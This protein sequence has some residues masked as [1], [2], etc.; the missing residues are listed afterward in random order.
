MAIITPNVPANA[1]LGSPLITPGWPLVAVV[2]A[3]PV[4]DKVL[5]EAPTVARELVVAS[6][7]VQ[8][9]IVQSGHQNDRSI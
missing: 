5:Q 6:T 8:K 9:A 1:S 4:A 3:H 2:H 7:T